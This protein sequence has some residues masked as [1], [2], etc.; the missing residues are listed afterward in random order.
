MH[1]TQAVFHPVSRIFE[2]RKSLINLCGK[3]KKS[4]AKLRCV[5]CAWVYSRTR[6]FVV[7]SSSG[8]LDCDEGF[9]LLS[10]ISPALL[11]FTT[12]LRNGPFRYC[13]DR[14]GLCYFFQKEKQRG[15][16]ESVLKLL[17]TALACSGSGVTVKRLRTEGREA[18]PG[19]FEA[20]P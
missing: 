9:L 10:F 6:L 5:E 18:S 3:M 20:E 17:K 12:Q 4:N 2:P 14:N 19:D 16:Y 8:Q 1:Q 11:R 15:H 7:R 13:R